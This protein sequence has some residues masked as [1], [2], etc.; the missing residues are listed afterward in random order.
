M[1]GVLLS[2]RAPHAGIAFGYG[3]GHGGCLPGS[4][5]PANGAPAEFMAGCEKSGM[6]KG[7]AG[8]TH[9]VVART[10]PS[11]PLCGGG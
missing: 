10:P 4:P 11:V 2:I 7:W 8:V 3:Y 6:E 9:F 1:V 5:Q